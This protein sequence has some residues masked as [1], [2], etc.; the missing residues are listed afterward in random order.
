MKTTFKDPL[1]AGGWKNLFCQVPAETP[2]KSPA[3]EILDYFGAIGL[4]TYVVLT[5]PIDFSVMPFSGDFP[6]RHSIPENHPA[7]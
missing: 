1:S 7:G 2:G 3:R 4:P 5:P 6:L